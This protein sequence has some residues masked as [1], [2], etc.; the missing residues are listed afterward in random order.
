MLIAK[1]RVSLNNAG[2]GYNSGAELGTAA[3]AGAILKDGCVVRGLG[4]HFADQAAKE[5]FDKL[6]RESNEIRS[7]FSRQFMR[8]PIDGTFVIPLKG[9]GKFFVDQLTPNPDIEV[10]VIEF[11]L[12]SAGDGLDMEEMQEWG[13]RVRNQLLRIPLGRGKDVDDEG[14]ASIE[15]LASCP[16][17][18]KETADTIKELVKFVRDGSLSRQDFK[19]SLEKIRME[20]DPAAL[21]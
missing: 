3:V 21:A 16:V 14:L 15:S 13:E 10:S 6:T 17:L 7:K 5:R 1:L 9:Q 4:T 12:S 8:T 11:E 19:D 20:M 18:A 2:I